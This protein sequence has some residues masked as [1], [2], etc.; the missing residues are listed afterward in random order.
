MSVEP[1]HDVSKLFS[2]DDGNIYRRA[3]TEVLSDIPFPYMLS[4]PLSVFAAA[5]ERG[6]L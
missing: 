6:N 4:E 5:L 1:I 3:V 2:D